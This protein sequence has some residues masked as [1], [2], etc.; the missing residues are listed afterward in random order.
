MFKSQDLLTNKKKKKKKKKK[1]ASSS[2]K[3][4]AIKQILNL[5]LPQSPAVFP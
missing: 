1:S 2:E 3:L 4:K 5:N